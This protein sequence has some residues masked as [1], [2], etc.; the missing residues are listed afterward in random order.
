[1]SKCVARE[2]VPH[3][4][5]PEPFRASHLREFGLDALLDM[6]TRFWPPVSPD[7]GAFDCAFQ[8]RMMANEMLGVG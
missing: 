2:F 7:A 6:G 5:P 4:C 3:F 1:M 8:V